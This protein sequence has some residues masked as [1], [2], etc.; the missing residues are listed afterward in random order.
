ML[1]A[2]VRKNMVG[3]ED[4]NMDLLELHQRVEKWEDLHTEFKDENVH[5][6]N[7]SASLVAFANTDGG[8][9]IIGV[10]N[11]HQV[12]GVTNADRVMQRLDQIAY[13]NCEPP[14]T[15]VQETVTA[16]D[17]AIVVV[18][19]IPKGDQ[20]PYRTNRGDYFIRTT[21]GRRRASRQELLRLF[22][23]TE[24]LYYD[25]T[26]VLRSSIA[27]ID[28]SAVEHFIQQTYQKTLEQM[29]IKYEDLLRNLGYARDQDG[30]LYPIMACM[31]FWGREPQRF[32][33]HAHIVAAR[34]PGKDFSASPSDNKQISGPMAAVLDD[35]VRFLRIHL[36]T[37]HNIQAFE[38]EVHSE[39]PEE[40]LREI[41]VNALAHRDY[42]LAAPIRVFVF[43]DRVEIRTPGGLPNTVTIDAIRLGAVHVLRNPTIY[44]LF[45]RLGLVTGIGTGVYRA[46][47]QVRDFT[48]QDPALLLEGNEF[49]VSLPKRNIAE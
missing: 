15:I 36:K 14:L 18:V 27:D 9:L 28:A 32:F 49:V 13:N 8:Q 2:V 41:L 29:G 16:D 40:A 1:S 47:Q 43:D 35:T 25:E 7:L 30:I 21:S 26:L 39:L 5:E 48:H 45:S 17:G 42:T 37:T 12:V 10:T 4:T 44:T 22:Q 46:I 33:P 20:R 19:N 24:S 3:S 38:P 11:T 34:I 23:A 31:L 6:D